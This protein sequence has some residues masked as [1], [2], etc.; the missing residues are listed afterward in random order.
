MEHQVV[1]FVLAGGSGNRLFAA[2]KGTCQAGRALRGEVQNYRFCPQQSDQFWYLFDLC[3][4]PIHE[5]VASA[6]PARWLAI[7]QLAKQSV[8]NSGIRAIEVCA[9]GR[10]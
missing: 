2:H 4:D 6:A 3:V 9:P 10:I 7:R 1:A 8:H 5:P